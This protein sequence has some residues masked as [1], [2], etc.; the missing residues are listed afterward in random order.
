MSGAE[1]Q[2]DY[3]YLEDI[4]YIMYFDQLNAIGLHGTYWHDRFGYKHSHG[5][6]NMTILDAEWTFK[7]SENAPNDLWV[8]VHTSDPATH[9]EAFSG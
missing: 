8:W 9:L 6:V 3:Y 2:V 5:C 1:G 4:P 7:W